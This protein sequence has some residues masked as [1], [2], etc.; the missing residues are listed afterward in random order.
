[1]ALLT[2]PECSGSVSSTAAHCP[3]CGYR[4]QVVSV[5]NATASVQKATATVLEKIRG[6]RRF[7]TRGNVFGLVAIA[8]S[9]AVIAGLVT[10]KR[11]VDEAEAKRLK[12]PQTFEPERAFD[13]LNIDDGENNEPHPAS[14]FFAR[15]AAKHWTEKWFENIGDEHTTFDEAMASAAR[16]KG[17]R[18]CVRAPF[19]MPSDFDET[20]EGRIFSG[21]FIGSRPSHAYLYYAVGPNKDQP[22]ESHDPARVFCG[23]A[24]GREHYMTTGKTREHALRVAGDFFPKDSVKLTEKWP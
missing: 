5:Q 21:V 2:C 8:V 13:E 24:L 15:W 10:Y 16:D 9:S 23:F 20:P 6:L 7:V 17:K 12:V 19:V 11:R 14:I 18:M 3:H 22:R 4:A 1:M